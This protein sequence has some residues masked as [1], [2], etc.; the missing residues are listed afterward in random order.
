VG[1]APRQ[2]KS[3]DRSIEPPVSLLDTLSWFSYHLL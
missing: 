1:N 2:L 3:K